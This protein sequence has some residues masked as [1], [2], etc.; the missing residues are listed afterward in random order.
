MAWSIG[1][2]LL[3]QSTGTSEPPAAAVQVGDAI[4]WIRLNS[5]VRAARLADC[6]RCKADLRRGANPSP[7][8]RRIAIPEDPV[9]FRLRGDHVGAVWIAEVHVDARIGPLARRVAQEGGNGMAC[10]HAANER[11][12]DAARSECRDTAGIGARGQ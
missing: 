1:T 9:P 11:S 8:Q 5:D 12:A 7:W 6:F 10:R 4:D 2:I 3:L